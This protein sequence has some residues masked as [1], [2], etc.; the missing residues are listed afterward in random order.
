MYIIKR[1][2][3]F[4]AWLEALAN[5]V[6]RKKIEARL[7][8]AQLGNFGYSKRLNE[9]LWEMKDTAPTGFRVYY[10]LMGDV[11]CFVVLGGFK[12][13]Q[14][15]DI[16]YATEVAKQLQEDYRNELH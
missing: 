8:R 13:T 9:V 4:N 10:T 1:T 3:E 16:A 2:E 11:V 7:S 12:K 15:D 14:S 6:A 5:P